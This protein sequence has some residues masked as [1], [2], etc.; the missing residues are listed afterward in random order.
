M[1]N[2]ARFF[3][4]SLNIRFNILYNQN[5][6]IINSNINIINIILNNDA[7]F[8]KILQYFNLD[9]IIFMYT[10]IKQSNA[11]SFI[12]VITIYTIL[13]QD[14]RPI[15]A[16]SYNNVSY[17]RSPSFTSYQYYPQSP[18]GQRVQLY[19][20]SKNRLCHIRISM[21]MTSTILTTSQLKIMMF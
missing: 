7:I 3:V 12:G 21:T 4:A 15:L 10:C 17:R 6:N 20:Q 18:F 11:H 14:E 13:I 2:V 19:T 8:R 9:L 5:K 16:L 1:V